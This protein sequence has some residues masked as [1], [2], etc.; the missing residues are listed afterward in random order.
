[1]IMENLNDL[2]NTYRDA[3]LKECWK[4]HKQKS[5]VWDLF[6]DSS[7]RMA[8]Y[9]RR[10]DEEKAFMPWAR[11]II[12]RCYIDNI[13]ANELEANSLNTVSTGY[14]DQYISIPENVSESAEHILKYMDKE[15]AD[16]IQAVYLDG[17]SQQEIAM[18]MEISQQAVSKKLKQ[19]KIKFKETYHE[20]FGCTDWTDH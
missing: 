8:R 14:I 11:I 18:E 6:Q 12:K 9:F 19:A 15:E 13:R 10:F 4:Y 2:L 7:I 5:D 17:R 1:M 20:Y 3:L 16:L